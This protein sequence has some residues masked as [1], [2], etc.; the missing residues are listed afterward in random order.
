MQKRNWKT[1]SERRILRRQAK[2]R[3]LWNMD[4]VECPVVP[5]RDHAEKPRDPT[6]TKFVSSLATVRKRIV[7]WET[8]GV[9]VPEIYCVMARQDAGTSHKVAGYDEL[10][11]YSL[12]LL[13]NTSRLH[14]KA[15]ILHCDLKPDNSLWDVDQEKVNTIDF[16]HAQEE[17]GKSSSCV[18]GTQGFIAPE[19]L[20]MARRREYSANYAPHCHWAH[21]CCEIGPIC[22]S[23][24]APNDSSFNATRNPNILFWEIPWLRHSWPRLPC[25]MWELSIECPW[26]FRYLFA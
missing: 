12:S 9:S 15:G 2:E 7:P 26:L 19:K 16:G 5:Q 8:A 6:P 22:K 11:S 14:S 1:K 18:R 23:N 17:T 24:K 4:G 10:V 3:L 13:Q 25:G 21:Q 20:T